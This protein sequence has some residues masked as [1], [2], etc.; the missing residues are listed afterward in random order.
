MIRLL[1]TVDVARGTCRSQNHLLTT[2]MGPFCADALFSLPGGL[3]KGTD[4]RII[5]PPVM[6]FAGRPVSDTHVFRLAQSY[7]NALDGVAIDMTTPGVGPF[8]LTG[9]RMTWAESP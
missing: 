6:V 1:F 7:R 2:G 4:Y 9:H 8:E 3:S 5:V